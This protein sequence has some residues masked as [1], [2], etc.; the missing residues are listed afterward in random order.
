MTLWRLARQRRGV[1]AA[2][3]AI[4]GSLVVLV[5]LFVL[6]VGLMAWTRVALNAAAA[7]AARCAV[8]NSSACPSVPNYAVAAVQNWLF[9]NA[10]SAAN[11]TVQ[12]GVS[13]NG[14]TGKYTIVTVTSAGWA[15][16]LPSV[17]PAPLSTPSITASSCYVSAL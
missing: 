12:T 17:L 11:V 10:I 9:P 13:C 1:V 4:C 3:F 2:E 6:E 16:M 8:L 7:N 5:M 15:T 14:A